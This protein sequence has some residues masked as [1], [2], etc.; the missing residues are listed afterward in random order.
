MAGMA[1]IGLIALVVGI[2]RARRSEKGSRKRKRS[3]TLAWI[4]GVAMVY[5]VFAAPVPEELSAEVEP[6]PEPLGVVDVVN[7]CQ[8]EIRA[9]LDAPN[10]ATFPGPSNPERT[11][12]MYF[13][14]D[15]S[16]S[17]LTFIHTENASGVPIRVGWS[18]VVD[19][20]GSVD[21]E[22]IGER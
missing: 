5:G 8:R 21:V 17:W 13:S 20:S 6:T 4:G 3:R 14:D 16:W 15:K 18:C 10:T 7:I 11:E 22:S 9:L 2:V 12:P 1:F 19:D